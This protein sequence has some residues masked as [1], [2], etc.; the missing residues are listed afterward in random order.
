MSELIIRK[1]DHRDIDTLAEMDKE[2]FSSPWSR[3]SFRQEMDE[4]KVAFYV[5]GEIDGVPAGYAG[6]WC[7]VDEGHITN[8]AVL[9]D[10]REKQVGS[11]LMEVILD[12]TH[13]NGI[14]DYTLEVRRSNKA[15]LA[16][17]R[18]FDFEEAGV[19]PRYYEDNGED[20]IIMWRREK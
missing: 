2:C 15:A 13:R 6:M 19:R 14:K 10:Y 9:P 11:R 12:V 16:L 18:K 17:Y 20:A 4:S 1:A 8:V 5:I 3:E 7:I